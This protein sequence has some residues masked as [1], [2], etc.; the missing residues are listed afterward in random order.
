M[1][2]FWSSSVCPSP[3]FDGEDF[4]FR[5]MGDEGIIDAQP[6][7]KI[8]VARGGE[9]ELAYEQPHV[10]LDDA[11]AYLYFVEAANLL[12]FAILHDAAG[13]PFGGDAG[14][15]YPNCAGRAAVC[16]LVAARRP[17]GDPRE[18]AAQVVAAI[19]AAL[20]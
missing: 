2:S 14:W 5:L 1:A 11:D 15:P 20:G 16:A 4:R 13:G 6:F 10:P 18:D 12:L 3:G 19:R 17:G 7:G 8:R 9:W